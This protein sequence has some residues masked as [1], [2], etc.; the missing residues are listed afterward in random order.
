MSEGVIKVNQQAIV[1][2]I[3]ARINKIKANRVY[4]LDTGGCTS[5]CWGCF[6]PDCCNP[7]CSCPSISGSIGTCAN[8]YTVTV[9][10][11]AGNMFTESLNGVYTVTWDAVRKIWKSWPHDPLVGNDV[12][13][14]V[15]CQQS[16][17][18]GCDRRDWIVEIGVYSSCY[19]IVYDISKCL[20][21]LPVECCPPIGTYAWS[22]VRI[23]VDAGNVSEVYVAFCGYKSSGET[24]P[25]CFGLLTAVGTIQISA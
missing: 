2:R 16:N 21:S 12:Y 4:A 11:F 10:G 19:K 15:N 6:C 18:G 1:N 9:D 5:A 14:N 7:V 8:T 20:S 3:K 22:D 17:Y 23:P 25:C 24:L 13:C